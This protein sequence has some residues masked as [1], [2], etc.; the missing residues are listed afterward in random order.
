MRIANKDFIGGVSVAVIGLVFLAGAMKM[1]IGD[2]IE[3]GPGY[4]PMLASGFV[5]VLGIVIAGM[6]LIRAGVR[7]DRPEWR[8]VLASLG[9][10]LAFGVLLEQIGLL[11]AIAIGIV[12]GAMGDPD[13]RT[14]QTWIL[15]IATALLG[16]LIFRV[17]LGLQ[18]PGFR[19]PSFLE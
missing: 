17:A 16:W 7:L 12:V 5:V 15:A 9:S 18:M 13:S 1:R 10:I 2:A 14:R 4:F 6:G 11:P 3:M 19:L 8:P